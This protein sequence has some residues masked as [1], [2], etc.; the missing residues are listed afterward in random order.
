MTRCGNDSSR[1]TSKIKNMPLLEKNKGAWVSCAC[2]HLPW[3]SSVTSQYSVKVSLKLHSC[4]IVYYL[5]R[6][7]FS[8]VS[9]IPSII[10]WTCKYNSPIRVFRDPPEIPSPLNFYA[11]KSRDIK[12]ARAGC[13]LKKRLREFF[14]IFAYVH[15]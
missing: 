7:T 11:L 3:T 10:P 5:V 6:F 2:K 12:E 4:K 13:G 8:N 14:F 15:V 9:I 1:I